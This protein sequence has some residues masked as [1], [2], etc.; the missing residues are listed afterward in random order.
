[1]VHGKLRHS[2]SQDS[3]AMANQDIEHILTTWLQENE[4][5]LWSHGLNL[6]SS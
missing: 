2:Q 1:M 5:T 4:S 3:N 6:F